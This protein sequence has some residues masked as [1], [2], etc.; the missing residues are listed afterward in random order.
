[1]VDPVSTHSVFTRGNGTTIK[2]ILLLGTGQM[3]A[4]GACQPCT[5]LHAKIS[6]RRES[7]GIVQIWEALKIQFFFFVISSM[8]TRICTSMAC[9]SREE[10]LPDRPSG[11]RFKI[12]G[13]GAPWPPED[14]GKSTVAASVACNAGSEALKPNHSCLSKAKDFER[15]ARIGH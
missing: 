2:E 11:A 12:Y 9:T 5:R 15:K 8:A 1:M 14:L 13:T 10:T 7:F 6:D 4:A 3:V